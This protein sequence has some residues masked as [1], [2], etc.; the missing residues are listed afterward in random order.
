MT[1]NQSQ[2]RFSSQINIEFFF[3]H[4]RTQQILFWNIPQIHTWTWPWQ[5]ITEAYE[6]LHD[7]DKRKNYDQPLERKRNNFSKKS[8]PFEFQSKSQICPKIL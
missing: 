3:S 2:E 4:E 7:S 1:I 6:V 5:T 8:L